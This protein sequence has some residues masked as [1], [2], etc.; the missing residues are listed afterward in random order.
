MKNKNTTKLRREPK[1]PENFKPEQEFEVL[2]Q[3]VGL[4]MMKVRLVDLTYPTRT[5]EEAKMM[6]SKIPQESRGNLQAGLVFYWGI[7]RYDNQP[8]R[9]IESVFDFNYAGQ[10]TQRDEYRATFILGIMLLKQI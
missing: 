10:I 5:D 9:D 4:R 8:T 3:E 7:G 2:I 6:L 1:L